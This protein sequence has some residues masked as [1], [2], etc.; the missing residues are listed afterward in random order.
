MNG[1]IVRGNP[2]DSIGLLPE[3]HP[4]RIIGAQAVRDALDFFE[5]VCRRHDLPMSN[6]S[7]EN[8]WIPTILGTFRPTWLCLAGGDHQCRGG[9]LSPGARRDKGIGFEQQIQGIHAHRSKDSV[10][11]ERR[12]QSARATAS[13]SISATY[14]KR[15]EN[16]I[17]FFYIPFPDTKSRPNPSQEDAIPAEN[18]KHRRSEERRVGKECRSRWSPYH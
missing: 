2:L 17:H 1:R 5:D 6:E 18:T 15:R 10:Y 11:L 7:R 8:V 14:Q 16:E 3:G 12:R 4:Y 9:R 13:P